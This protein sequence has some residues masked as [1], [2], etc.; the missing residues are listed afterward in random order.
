MFRDPRSMPRGPRLE[1]K[2]RPDRNE[3]T[4]RSERSDAPRPVRSANQSQEPKRQEDNKKPK[5]GFKFRN[6][7]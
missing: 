5:V 7:K 6:R 4:D 3:R 2:P 1:H